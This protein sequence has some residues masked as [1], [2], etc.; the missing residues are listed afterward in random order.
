MD[1][2]KFGGD[3]CYPHICD[4][5]FTKSVHRITH[6]PGQAPAIPPAYQK[7]PAAAPNIPRK[8]NLELMMENFIATQAQTNKDFLNQNIHTSE[9]TK[10]LVNKVDA[11]ATHNKMLET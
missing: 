9:Q 8:S 10:Q 11:L 3:S 4:T 2:R 6:T 5:K 7:A 1:K